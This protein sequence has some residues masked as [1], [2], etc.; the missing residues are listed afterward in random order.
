MTDLQGHADLSARR[1]LRSARR[2]C[3]HPPGSLWPH[4]SLLL[5]VQ[6]FGVALGAPAV[7]LLARKQLA[8][9]WAGLGFALAYLLYPPTQWLVLDDFHPVAL[10]APLLLWG[11]WFLDCDRLV[12]F[13][14]VAVAASLTKEQVGLTVAA[15]GLWYAFRPGRRREGLAI[16]AA[17]AA[18]SAIAMLVVVPHF[19]PG[20]ASP[21]AGRYDRVGGSP[22]GIAK[23]AVTDPATIVREATDPRDRRY[24]VDLLV[25][26]L[27]L[28]A[29][30]A[31]SG[32]HRRAGDRPQPPLL[33][34]DA[35]LDP[36]SLHGRGDPGPLRRGNLR[37][38]ATAPPLDHP[39]FAA[40]AARDRGPARRLRARADAAVARTSPAARR[41]RPASTSSASTRKLPSKSSRSSP[42][43]T[44]SARPTRSGAHLSARRRVLSFP[45]TRGVTWVA[46]DTTRPSYL[47]EAVAP[48][49]FAEALRALEDRGAFRLVRA[50]DG[51]RVYRLREAGG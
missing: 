48:A 42:P 46:V 14:A 21:F 38:R 7:Y 22:S 45:L 40:P 12:A 17:G 26:L 49:E 25:P 39:P 50:E 41:S 43:V 15:M 35:N 23:T 10:A 44:R 8:S 2:R 33:D 31:R 11:F 36:L 6:A 32:P 29:R 24:V 16:A 34:P 51:V 9:E 3:S 37:R 13:A 47:D 20:G 27:A 28:P 30:G 18:V 4:P 1:S 5:A 19:A